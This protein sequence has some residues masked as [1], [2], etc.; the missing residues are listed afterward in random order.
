MSWHE[1]DF[2][3]QLETIER[4][5]RNVPALLVTLANRR[6]KQAF[7]PEVTRLISMAES[8]AQR[9]GEEREHIGLWR[10]DGLEP[11][12]VLDQIDTELEVFIHTLNTT[13]PA[14]R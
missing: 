5:C 4:D 14:S 8:I 13:L 12:D 1:A 10:Q 6:G 2:L 7:S 3:E 11:E 9:C